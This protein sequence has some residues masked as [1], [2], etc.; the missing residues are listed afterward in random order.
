MMEIEARLASTTRA[1]DDKTNTA[2][3]VAGLLGRKK[4]GVNMHGKRNSAIR[5]YVRGFPEQNPWRKLMGREKGR[6]EDF[7]IG[8]G[9]EDGKEGEEEFMRRFGGVGGVV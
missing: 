1:E 2:V 9:F 4:S 3:E 8:I 5:E 7:G 6:G